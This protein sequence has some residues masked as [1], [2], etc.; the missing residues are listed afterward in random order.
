MSTVPK[1][2]EIII[3]PRTISTTDIAKY[4][5]IERKELN[6]IF[7]E[8]QWIKRKYFLWFATT[9][10]GKEK[11][12][13]K[14]NREILWN[15]S[16]LGDKELILAIKDSKNIVDETINSSAYKMQIYKKYK[17]AGYT[18]WDYSKE[19][20]TYD[21]NIHFVAKKN[22]E[23]LL[24]H[25]K[26]DEKDINL[27]DLVDFIENKKSFIAENP[28]FGMYTLKIKYIISHFSLTEEAFKYLNEN[29]N[30]IFYEIFK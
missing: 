22:K 7:L 25:C 6:K 17:K 13:K 29:K 23:V 1:K 4:F 8:L 5:D 9:E 14:E 30:T 26:S 27:E 10:L 28:I 19:K 11:G 20:G 12:A 18:I 3:S 2:N 15:R 21:R 16:I 24:I